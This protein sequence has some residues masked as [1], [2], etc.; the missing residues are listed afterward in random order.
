MTPSDRKLAA[1]AAHERDQA[2]LLADAVPR[3]E[4]KLTRAREAVKDAEAAVKNAK[5]AAKE[6]NERATAAE[7]AA[8]ELVSVNG[9]NATAR[10]GVAEIRGGQV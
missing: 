2:T 6:A 3:A 5:A 4:A 10:A 7:G 9:D 8:R 1:A